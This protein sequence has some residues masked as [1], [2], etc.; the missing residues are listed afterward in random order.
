MRNAVIN[1]TQR[2]A[3]EAFIGDAVSATPLHPKFQ[4]EPRSANV[5]A[6]GG[7]TRTVDYPAPLGFD[8]N[9]TSVN[10]PYTSFYWDAEDTMF[11]VYAGPCNGSATNIVQALTVVDPKT[12]EVQAVWHPPAA[13]AKSQLNFVYMQLLTDTGEIV[14]SNINGQIFILKLCRDAR[15]TPSFEI[16]RVIDLESTGVLQNI[17]LLN[18][19]MDAAG[20]VWFTTGVTPGVIAA[21]TKNSTIMGYVE[22][23]GTVHS[24]EMPNQAVENGISLSN[25][26]IFVVT[27][28]SGEDDHANAVGFMHALRPGAGTSVEV[29]W[30]ATYQAGSR[31]K[32][33]AFAR[34]SGI[35]PA[36]LGNDFVALN[37]NSDD[38]SNLLVWAQNSTGKDPKPICTVPMF[39]PNGSWSD[40]A[41]MAHWDGK[42]YGVTVVNMYNESSFQ[43]SQG[44]INDPYNNLTT[45]SPGISKFVVAGDGSGYHLEWTNPSRMTTDLMLSTKT[46]LLYG[47]DQSEEL[48]NEGEYV[49]YTSAIDWRTGKTVWKARTGAGGSYNNFYRTTYLG[50]DGTLYQPVQ[51]GLVLV[52]DGSH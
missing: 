8:L 31:K 14:L 17:T 41:A 29:V 44:D 30:N 32:P 23:N 46:G 15:A 3:G 2:S 37:D 13:Y 47:Y 36:L 28:P 50:P 11:S 52:K 4:F 48:A 7:N 25:T 39:K 9:I 33:N 35:T 26:T 21:A 18:S 22:P 6:D 16:L 38:Q 24:L 20:N 45:Q 10:T 34:G 12:L 43:A 27:G 49:W 40:N 42:D 5:H 1:S 51:G 19:M